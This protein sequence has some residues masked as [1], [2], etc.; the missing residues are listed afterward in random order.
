MGAPQDRRQL[1]AFVPAKPPP[2][3]AATDAWLAARRSRRRGRQQRGSAAVAA[4]DYAMDPNTGQLLPA[5]GGGRAAEQGRPG[6]AADEG[7]WQGGSPASILGDADLLGTP[8][9]SA[10]GSGGGGSRGGTPGSVV[11]ATPA[12]TA[13]TAAGGER[14]ASQTAGQ[15]QPAG[16]DGSGTDSDGHEEGEEEEV[17]GWGQGINTATSPC[18]PCAAETPLLRCAPH[19]CIHPSLWRAGAPRQPQVRRKHIFLL[20]PVPITSPHPAPRLHTA[21]PRSRRRSSNCARGSR[22]GRPA[23]AGG[24]AAIA[25]CDASGRPGQRCPAAAAAA[26]PLSAGSGGGR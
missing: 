1:L 13:G 21:A 18:T 5:P 6:S 19:L 8:T 17:G 9:L 23:D 20:Q 7:E 10:L 22:P 26:A 11:D 2:S 12:S 15:D 16:V 24:P 14:R 4:A 25:S 3:R